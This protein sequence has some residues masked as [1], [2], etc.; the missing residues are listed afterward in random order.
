VQPLGGGGFLFR[1]AQAMAI[2]SCL[3]FGCAFVRLAAGR[4]GFG[5]RAR[6]GLCFL[7]GAGGLRIRFSL[8]VSLGFRRIA[9]ARKLISAMTSP[10]FTVSPS[11]TSHLASLPSSMV[12]DSAG[13]RM[14]VMT[15]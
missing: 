15:C 6:L 3:L 10:G 1:R 4:I 7:R 13:I 2:V 11:L 12:G 14:S 9:F 5:I 8:S